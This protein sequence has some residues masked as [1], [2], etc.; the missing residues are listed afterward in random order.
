MTGGRDQHLVTIDVRNFDTP[1][2]TTSTASSVRT[3][4]QYDTYVTIDADAPLDRAA[5]SVVRRVLRDPSERRRV[6]D[7]YNNR[8]TGS[9]MDK[10]VVDT[11]RR[12][13]LNRKSKMR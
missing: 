11:L 13:V 6:A 2:F 7:V 3:S 10:F 5:R 4:I 8:K 9:D 12:A 1:V